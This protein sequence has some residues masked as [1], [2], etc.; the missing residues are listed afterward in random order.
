MAGVNTTA[1]ISALLETYIINARAT[2]EVGP[3][4]RRLMWEVP[5]PKGKGTSVN[6]PKFGTFTA[7]Q[8]TRGIRID[9][10]QQITVTNTQITP[11]SIAVHF[12]LDEFAQ[13]TAREDVLAHLGKRAG[14]A[15]NRFEDRDCLL[16]LDGLSRSVG[17]GGTA[18]VGH[19]MAAYALLVGGGSSGTDET[20]EPPF[21]VVLHPFA[22]HT[23]AEDLAGLS[24]GGQ[25]TSSTNVIASGM[26]LRDEVLQKYLV[27][28]LAG[29]NVYATANLIPSGGTIRGG[30][31][32]SDAFIYVP[33]KDLTTKQ[34]ED[35]KLQGWDVVSTK[36]YGRGEFNDNF[37]VELNLA[38]A[39]PSS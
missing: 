18:K 8:F 23:I 19:L 25:V 13:D 26:Q 2:N 5:L 9:Q 39:A 1:Q 21:H 34:Q 11:I 35:I 37:G 36:I 17:S 38:A 24:N 27:K 30:V 28:Q 20:A 31:F 3:L 16:L 4:M 29:M 10:A 7:Y 14:E 15:I 6:V 12:V 32:H 33:F 22:Y